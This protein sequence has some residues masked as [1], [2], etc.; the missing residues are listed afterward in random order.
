MTENP[1]HWWYSNN[2]EYYQGPCDSR[3]EAI[4]PW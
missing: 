3:E 1:F 4:G 2:E